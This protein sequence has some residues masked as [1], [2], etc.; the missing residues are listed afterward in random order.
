MQIQ[1]SVVNEIVR[2]FEI[3]N[4][5]PIEELRSRILTSRI[6]FNMDLAL[7]GYPFDDPP[8]WM[9]QDYLKSVIDA[10]TFH[11]NLYDSII[12][13]LHSQLIE[14]ITKDEIND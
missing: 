12:D 2:R 3:L 6:R 14:K 8:K 5:Q 11:S 10:D 1:E 4:N 13:N 9:D 7:I